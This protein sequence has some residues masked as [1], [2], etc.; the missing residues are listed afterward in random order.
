MDFDTYLH[1][2]SVYTFWEMFGDVGGLKELAFIFASI[3][4]GIK[5]FLFGSGL[6]HFLLSQLFLMGRKKQSNHLFNRKPAK[7]NKC[8][9]LRKPSQQQMMQNGLD[10]IDS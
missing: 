4:M 9:C 1:K 6:D 8:F 3:T 7:F 5:A 2:R 10:K